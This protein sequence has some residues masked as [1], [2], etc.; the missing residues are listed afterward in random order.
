[1][2]RKR[3]ITSEIFLRTIILNRARFRTKGLAEVLPEV[4]D[5]TA[6]NVSN[7]ISSILNVVCNNRSVLGGATKGTTV[8][9]RPTSKFQ[10]SVSAKLAD[11]EQYFK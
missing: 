8:D 1:M 5:S 7:A 6:K 10:L 11:D 4:V 2:V 9:N 3:S